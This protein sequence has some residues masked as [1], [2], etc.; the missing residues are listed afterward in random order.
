MNL[1]RKDIAKEEG[2]VIVGSN[3]M[4]NA[5]AIECFQSYPL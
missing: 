3:T 5:A 1:Q 2:K 4:R